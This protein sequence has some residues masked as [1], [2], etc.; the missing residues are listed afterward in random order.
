M[1][2]TMQVKLVPSSINNKTNKESDKENRTK[3]NNSDK[4]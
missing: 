1:A 3:N 4:K 2:F